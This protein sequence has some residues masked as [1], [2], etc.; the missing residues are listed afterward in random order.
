MKTLQHVSK[1]CLFRGLVI[2]IFY[3]TNK[4]SIMLQICDYKTKIPL[5]NLRRENCPLDD[6][7]SYIYTTSR[8]YKVY[9]I[10]R[11]NSQF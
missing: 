4:P 6:V 9:T 1:E 5:G 8:H 7:S 2:I 10:D 11:Q 3:T